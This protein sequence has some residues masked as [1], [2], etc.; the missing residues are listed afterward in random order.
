[1]LPAIQHTK[2]QQ[3]VAMPQH[4]PSPRWLFIT[5]DA[6]TISIDSETCTQSTV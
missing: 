6:G 3:L 4:P 1:M 5:C 2:T